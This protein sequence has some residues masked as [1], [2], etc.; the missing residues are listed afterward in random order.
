MDKN[1]IYSKAKIVK[2]ND[3]VEDFRLGVFTTNG[4]IDQTPQMQTIAKL[5]Q[6]QISINA[7]QILKLCQDTLGQVN[8]LTAQL[9]QINANVSNI[10]VSAGVAKDIDKQ[11]I[12]AI[13]DLKNYAAF[14]EQATFQMETK[15]LKTSLAIA[16]KIIGV[17][18]GENS[19][20]IAKETINN[21]LSKIKTASKIMIHLNPKDYEMLKNDLNLEATHISLIEDANVTPGGV[22]I[23][24]DLGNFDG[25][26]EAKV[27]SMLESLDSV[28]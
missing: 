4:E 28:I 26:I 8:N 1:N 22:V 19:S 24:S 13:K 3:G 2:S 9:N 10:Q 5:D 18:I 15:V 11:V 27:N 16:K 21:I 7:D 20:R 17:E 25:N 23:A 12:Q 6:K 14:F